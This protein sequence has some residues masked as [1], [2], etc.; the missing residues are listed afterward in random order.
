MQLTRRHAS[1]LLSWSNSSI[2]VFLLRTPYIFYVLCPYFPYV[3]CTFVS[4]PISWH[5][6]TSCR[7]KSTGG[8]VFDDV[9]LQESEWCEYDD[10]NSLSLEIMNVQWEIVKQNNKK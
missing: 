9:D 3:R 2:V 8:T 6:Q 5:L 7:V 10:D 4:E 1:L